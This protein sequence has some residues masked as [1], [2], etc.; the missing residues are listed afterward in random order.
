MKYLLFNTLM[1]MK[2]P[3][4]DAARERRQAQFLKRMKIKGGERIIDLGGTVEFWRGFPVPLK[5]T[6]VNLPDPEKTVDASHELHEIEIL[7]GDACDVNFANDLS[8]DIVFSNSVIEHVGAI[9]K[10]RAMAEEVLRLAPSYWVQTPSIWFPIE[11]HCNMPF[12][13]AYPEWLKRRLISRWYKKLPA[14]TDMVAGTT[15]LLRAEIL[16]LFPNCILWTEWKFGFPKSYVAYKPPSNSK[17]RVSE[18]M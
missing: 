7:D 6:I 8:Y 14:W 4:S 9:D 3:F 1:S 10:R 2:K 5:L 15:V 13:W 11:A 17:G 18:Q 12:W 16:S